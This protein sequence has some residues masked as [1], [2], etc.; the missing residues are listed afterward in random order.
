MAIG[1]KRKASI[2]LGATTS[3]MDKGLAEAK[4]KLRSFGA[5]M[6]KNFSAGDAK[7]KFGLDPKKLMPGGKKGAGG[8]NFGTGMFKA[9]GAGLAA[10]GAMLLGGGLLDVAGEIMAVEKALTRFQIAGEVSD[11]TM[12]DFRNEL[13]RVSNST[14]V[15]RAEL[16]SGAQ[17]YV[18]LT[19]DAKGAIAATQLF[20]E[21]S[22]GTGA[23][24]ADVAATAA[25][26]RQ[27]LKI[28]PKNFRE[29]F[30]VLVK[31]GKIGAIEIKDL[32]TKMA[33]IAPQ[34]STFAGAR[35][36]EG[37]SELGAMMQ[38]AK[39]GFGSAD[40]AATGFNGMMTQ[41][42]RNQK[43][44]KKF[45]V[46]V[47]DPKTGKFK[48]LLQIVR[49]IST[50]KKLLKPGALL[51]A[52]GE[53]K[54][55]RAMG[56]LIENL[57]EIDR[58]KKESLN[59]DQ[60]A[61][62]NMAFQ[63]STAGK[64]A[65]AMETA[66]NKIAE[67][68]TPERIEAFADA[69]VKV[70]DLFTKIVDAVENLFDDAGIAEMHKGDHAGAAAARLR[71]DNKVDKMTVGERFALG[72][73]MGA[74]AA[75]EGDELRKAGMERL[76]QQ[77]LEQNDPWESHRLRAFQANRQPVDAAAIGRSIVDALSKSPLLVKLDSSTVAKEVKNSHA[78]RTPRSGR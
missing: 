24:L 60:V 72:Q 44:L 16:V 8:K 78:A 71:R 23:S 66:K 61:K 37:M 34:F 64:L 43:K 38:V 45:G 3:A 56:V 67:A 59:S 9:M 65:R 4:R 73:K 30:D 11:R 31:Q 74:E 32:A 69:L 68:F 35:S 76:S 25:A 22:A 50:N 63:A 14:G 7:A 2:E 57:G 5:D 54:A 48:N 41:L 49:D 28:D 70:V 58:I 51:E 15:S 12:V 55:V 39:Q 6:R 40:E 62:D 42:N 18:S 10:G 75:F 52:L 27:N 29:A 36:V 46:N 33:N 17:A 20:A 13:V 19:G 1:A 21:V 53:E 47:V 26:L 77:L